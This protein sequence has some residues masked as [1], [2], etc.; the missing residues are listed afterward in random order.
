MQSSTIPPR[1]ISINKKKINKTFIDYCTEF[2]IIH[3]AT[4]TKYENIERFWQPIHNDIVRNNIQLNSYDDLMQYLKTQYETVPNS[5]KFGY[6][7]IIEAFNDYHIQ[8][9]TYGS[10]VMMKLIAKRI[11]IYASKQN[12]TTM[13]EIKSKLRSILRNFD[14][15]QDDEISTK[16]AEFFTF[17]MYFCRYLED[18]PEEQSVLPI[19]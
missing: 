11:R 14:V 15:K 5:R 12:Y 19:F 8:F 2:N 3:Y 16:N 13:G 7:Y 18:Y 9:A 10:D 1:F 6:S 17:A 4:K